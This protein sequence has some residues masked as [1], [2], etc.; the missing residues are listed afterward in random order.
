MGNVSV[1]ADLATA[2]LFTILSL[3]T[4]KNEITL[5]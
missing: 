1:L 4:K 2:R 5:A 3:T